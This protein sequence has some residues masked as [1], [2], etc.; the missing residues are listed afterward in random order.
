MECTAELF[1]ALEKTP[2]PF[3]SLFDQIQSIQTRD[4][5]AA[6]KTACDSELAHELDRQFEF[7]GQR[8]INSV[9]HDALELHTRERLAA[10][11]LQR[12]TRHCDILLA[13]P[14]LDIDTKLRRWWWILRQPSYRAFAVRCGQL[15]QSDPTDQLPAALTEDELSR[16]VADDDGALS[17]LPTTLDDEFGPYVCNFVIATQ[18][19]PR[20]NTPP[21]DQATP[22]AAALKAAA[23]AK[24]AAEVDAYYR[25]PKATLV[26][27]S[28]TTCDLLSLNAQPEEALALADRVI[29]AIEARRGHHHLDTPVGGELRDFFRSLRDQLIDLDAEEEEDVWSPASGESDAEGGGGWSSP[30]LRVS[31]C[32]ES[33][34]TT[35]RLIPRRK[36]A[37]PLPPRSPEARRCASASPRRRPTSAASIY[38]DRD[39]PRPYSALS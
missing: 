4:N 12:L 31:P 3:R 32:P 8:I 39:P 1:E 34:P 22:T 35:G 14:E 15:E 16:D 10:V 30:E 29:E 11:L 17:A 37:V 20:P 7:V 19:P 28:V 38:A 6:A 2:A 21:P 27:A 18:I 26:R 25:G 33:R 5:A 36:S 23:A 13:E 24:A 9:G